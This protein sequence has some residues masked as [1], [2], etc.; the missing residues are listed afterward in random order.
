MSLTLTACKRKKKKFNHRTSWNPQTIKPT[1]NISN[2]SFV[3]NACS[4]QLSISDPEGENGVLAVSTNAEQALVT[5]SKGE[6]FVSKAHYSTLSPIYFS[7][8]AGEKILLTVCNKKSDASFLC[9]DDIVAFY[10]PSAKKRPPLR[11][12]ASRV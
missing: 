5:R 6:D 2:I 1:W 7:V 10:I 9:S 8:E 3:Y 12:I 4:K 11:S